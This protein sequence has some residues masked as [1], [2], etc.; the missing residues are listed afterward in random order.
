MPLKK[1]L[2]VYLGLLAEYQG[3]D[4]LLEAIQQLK[5]E[6]EDFHLLLMGYPSVEHYRARAA[7]L[8]VSH[9]VTFTGRIPYQ[10]AP[11]YLSLGDLA[12]APKTSAT[13]GSG[14]I[15]NYMS[16]ALPTAAFDTPVSHEYLGDWGLYASERTASA[17]AATLREVLDMPVAERVALGRRL[18]ERAET[19]FSWDRVGEQMVAVYRAL[20]EGE[21][22]PRV[23]VRQGVVTDS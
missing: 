12:V 23:M 9:L 11:R 15:L 5:Q 10:D 4:L 2:I 19:L 1:H 18:R 17:L 6:R 22:L 8:G 13:E 16:M 14:K 20:I 7:E 3:I 21:P